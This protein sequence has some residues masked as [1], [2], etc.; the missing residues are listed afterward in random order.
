MKAAWRARHALRGWILESRAGRFRDPVAKLRFLRQKQGLSGRRPSNA[1]KILR[2]AAAC[3]LLLA[4]I[5]TAFDAV[6]EIEPANPPPEPPE[7]WRVEEKDGVELFSNGLRIENRMAVEGAPRTYPVYHPETLGLTRWRSQPAGIVYHTTE[8]HIAPFSPDHNG[9]LRRVGRWVLE[10]VRDSRSYHFVIDR[11][12]RVHRVVRESDAAHH[13]GSSIWADEQSLYVNLN[14]SF[15]GI[16]F[17]TETR[18][19]ARGAEINQA[20]I[21]AGRVLTEMLR[22]KYGIPAANCVTH[23]QVSVAPSTMFVGNHLDWSANFPFEELGLANNYRIPLPAV[24]IFGFRFDRDFQ[25]ATDSALGR[26]LAM[27][28]DLFRRRASALRLSADQ[29]RAAVQ[30]R[31][32]EIV[33]ALATERSAREKTT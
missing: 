21:H 17:E 29:H 9:R 16:S 11:F 14:A 8:S 27:G 5:P 2:V 4:P 7:I 31:Y 26:G 15:L 10:Y 23:A 1:G 19:L 25:K 30:R 20:Q 3:L 33:K 22:R 28:E 24:A 18:D 32:R 6:W 12:G 13:A